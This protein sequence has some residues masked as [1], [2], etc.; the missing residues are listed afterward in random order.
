[1][2]NK[3]NI[4]S[5]IM[6]STIISILLLFVFQA[7]AVTLTNAIVN[8]IGRTYGYYLAQ[9][10][11]LNEISKMYPSLS[12]QA[13]I[14]EME[15][16]VAFLSSIKNMDSVMG[17]G[18]EWVNI[19]KQI[20]GSIYKNLNITQ[21]TK[22]QAKA[23]IELVR[24]RA[25][26]EIESPVIEMLLLFNPAYEKQPV[27]EF[28]DGY[29][30]KYFSNG[31]GKAKGVSFSIQVPGSWASK[32]ARRPN[33]VRK[34]VSE[35]GRGLEMIMVIV[36][37]LPFPAGQK[38]TKQDVQEILDLTDMKD[39][40]PENAVY[41]DSGSLTIE[42]LPGFW[43]RYSMEMSRVRL[44]IKM[45]IIAYTIYYDNKMIQIQ[46]QVGAE[47][48]TPQNKILKRFENFEPIF[49]LVANS[50]VIPSMYK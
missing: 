1:M 30:K 29:R 47:E 44:K 28:N 35:N 26:G 37:K 36:K 15:F 13:R 39:L 43:Q 41:K 14:S 2:T 25:K 6:Y 19:K 49:D 33:I 11:S 42:N 23:F 24:R 48:K 20:K 21:L 50:F 12:N 40:L 45:E 4:S 8:D 17:K 3:V 27:K 16:D 22:Q 5:S 46:C 18:K 38:V 32:E 9:K 10:Y 7:H 34:F 31:S